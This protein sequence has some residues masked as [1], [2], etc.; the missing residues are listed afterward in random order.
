MEQ[1]RE[2]DKALDEEKNSFKKVIRYRERHD[3]HVNPFSEFEK[4]DSEE[5]ES[6]IEIAD[7]RVSIEYDYSIGYD[8]Q[9][10]KTVLAELTADERDYLL[11]Y[12]GNAKKNVPDPI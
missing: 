11:L 7:E 10:L 2:L 6:G 12:F 1:I 3:I 4:F 9:I 8:M 5:S